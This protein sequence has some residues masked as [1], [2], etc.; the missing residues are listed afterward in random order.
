MIDSWSGGVVGDDVSV[1]STAAQFTVERQCRNRQERR[2]DRHRPHRRELGNYTIGRTATTTGNIT[3][4]TV[5]LSGN[6][7]YDGTTALGAGAVSIVTGVGSQTL[8]Y[9]GATA[10]DAHVVA[11]GNYVTGI[12]LQDAVDGS[13]G[14]AANYA[15]PTLNAANAP[16]TITPRALTSSASIAGTLTR[17]YDGSTT[18]SGASVGGTVSGGIAGDTLTLDTGGLSL[19]YDSAHA[20]TASAIVASGSAAFL[21]DAS[22][23]GSQVSDYSFTGPSIVPAAASV[24]PAVLT[25]TLTNTG[26][27]KVYD[28]TTAAPAGFVPAW[29]V[30]GL[31]GGDTAA[32]V[33]STGA[34]Y[35]SSHVAEAGTVTVSG[36]S[37]GAI[38]GSN[39]SLASDYALAANSANVAAAIT[40]RNVT[41]AD[42]LVADKVYDGT[43]NALVTHWGSAATG[44]S[45]ETLALSAADA[46]F[47]DVNAGANRTVTVSGYALADGLGGRAS[48]YQLTSTSTSTTASIT[49]APLLITAYDDAKFVTQADTAGYD[50]VSYGG[51]VNGETSTVLGG[52][53][54]ILRS[55]GG[56]DAAGRY[57]AVLVPAGLTSSNYA[58]TY[59]KGDYLIVPAEQLLV[60]AA[61]TTTTYGTSGGYAVT[62][63]SYLDDAHVLSTLTLTAS[64]GNTYTFGDGASGTVTFT[65]VPEGAA[66]SGSGHVAAG[67]YQLA[68]TGVTIAGTNFD[69]LNFVGG[70]AVAPKS[71]A[72]MAGG[73]TKMYDGT[74]A[75]TNLTLDLVGVES[76]DTVTVDGIGQFGQRNVG[77]GLLYSVSDMT[78]GGPDG[79]NY[80]LVGGGALSGSNGAITRAAL[81]VSG[82]RAGDKVYDGSTA[83]SVTTGDAVFGGLVAGDDLRVA[84]VS[85]AFS[86]KN[87]GGGKTV[88]LTSTYAGADLGNYAIIDQSTTTAAITRLDAVTWVGGA[89]GNWFDP[90]NW[91]GGAV[92]DLANVANVVIPAGVVVSFDTGGAVAPAQTGPVQLDSLGNAGNLSQ[93]TGA[94]CGD[95][96]RDAGLVRADRRHAR[97]WR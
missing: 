44:I 25:P 34:V 9:A 72:A 45:G 68:G 85:G 76:G 65:L 27:T 62:S 63:A 47:T 89:F 33:S 94:L 73:V 50:G 92:P 97:S 74:T 75:A 22:A 69:A 66:T 58:I 96:R 51:L 26:V 2:G 61:N 55:N 87:V 7:V 56:T 40:P 32:T 88:T 15:L 38:S 90:A 20:A 52:T 11:S 8:G 19:A 21:I 59:S 42:V 39:G 30:S 3:P 46:A 43:A 1:S 23:A 84:G 48:D 29:S 67:S 91:A 54:S 4:R 70:L 79:G 93:A 16:V 31:I 71:I 95:R 64:D 36:P 82:I 12:T 37:I 80:R 24:T 53:L 41:V 28:G 18:A 60:R 35:D 77:S 10:Q 6:K 78:L 86:D 13:G 17:T 57:D 83:A 49:P 5:A 81:N 14:L